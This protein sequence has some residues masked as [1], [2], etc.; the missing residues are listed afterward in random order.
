M[1]RIKLNQSAFQAHEV[2]E[3]D[4]VLRGLPKS[5]FGFIIAAPNAGKSYSCLSIGYEVATGA[6]LFG[7]SQ[8]TMPQKVLYWPCEDG[9]SETLT[10]IQTHF[11]SFSPEIQSVLEQNFELYD[12][13]E[14]ICDPSGVSANSLQ[15][16]INQAQ[17]FDLVI[18]DTIREASGAC[19]EVKDDRLIKQALQT[20]AKEANVAVLCTHHLTK[21]AARGNEKI[22]N[23][24]A[25][26][27][28]ETL[29]NSRYQLFLNK[30]NK[31]GQA[32]ARYTISHIKDNFVPKPFKIL[33][34]PVCW[35]DCDLPYSNEKSFQT[36]V[37]ASALKIE[38]KQPKK[39]KIQVATDLD[40]L[41]D[42]ITV[43]M[44][45][46]TVSKESVADAKKYKDETS[47]FTDERKER[48]RKYRQ[49]H[50]RK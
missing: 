10:R 27:L 7:L 8:H 22:T 42:P 1:T 40:E 25:S 41:E 2:D 38:P 13:D 9:V 44:S 48:L 39:E 32:S 6:S 50:S 24:S 47:I 29:A 3:S 5:K 26:G 31:D 28:S 12:S 21:E 23:V 46:V 35:S 4:Y 37:S 18:I 43:D 16:L 30:V 33:D 45:Q 15:A 14:P 34:M 20:L 36:L 11:S 19:D 49:Q 17:E